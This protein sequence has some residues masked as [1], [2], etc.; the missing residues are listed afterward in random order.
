MAETS[1]HP[2]IYPQWSNQTEFRLNKFNE[3]KD[4]FL[5]EVVQ[6]QAINKGFRK[7]IAVVD[8]FDKA[9]IDL[10]AINGEISTGIMK[11][12]LKTTENN[13][14][15]HNKIIML[16]RIKLNIVETW[17][18]KV[19]TDSKEDIKIKKSL[20]CDSEKKDDWKKLKELGWMTLLSRIVVIYKNASKLC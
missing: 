9:L 12:S 16:A 8:Y 3:I 6:R 10:Y 17:I 4:N 13:D 20:K 2:V 15:K 1:I 11:R 18:S 5:V 14:K 7:C 19:L